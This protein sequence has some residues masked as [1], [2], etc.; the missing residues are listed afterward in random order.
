MRQPV[1]SNPQR[2]FGHVALIAFAA[3]VA[4]LIAPSSGHAQSPVGPGTLSISLGLDRSPEAGIWFTATR[5]TRIGLL[6]TIDR[7][8]NSSE[9]PGDGTASSSRFRYTVGPALKWYLVTD[10]DRVAPYWHTSGWV[11]GDDPP[12]DRRVTTLG[13]DGGFGVDWFPVPQVSFGGY[14]GLEFTYERTK[15][16]DV[17]NT[18]SRLGTLTAGLQM[19]I[20]F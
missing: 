18:F 8:S 6:G 16:G 12:G 13:V 2:R 3:A 1:G 11:G 9:G 4:L 10:G 19:H 20:Y 14:T 7:T 17:T 5:Y 15:E